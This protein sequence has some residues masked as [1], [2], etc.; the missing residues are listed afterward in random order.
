MDSPA[1]LCGRVQGTQHRN[2]ENTIASA[3]QSLK[4]RNNKSTHL[5]AIC[6]AVSNFDEKYNYRLHNEVHKIINMQHPTKN[7][8]TGVA[9]AYRST[10]TAR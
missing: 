6:P 2:S 8:H 1:P 5:L 4:R 9:V 7:K 3:A 10:V